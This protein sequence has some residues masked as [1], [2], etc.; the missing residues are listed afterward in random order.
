MSNYENRTVEELK[1]LL[2]ERGLP[3]FGNKADLIARLRGRTSSPGS[4]R[5][6]S[7]G[8][9]GGG[10]RYDGTLEEL[11]DLLYE[12]GLPLSG[13]RNFD[14]VSGTFEVLGANETSGDRA[15]GGSWISHWE[16]W[17]RREARECVFVGC[18]DPPTYGGHLH[19]KHKRMHFIGP[20]CAHHN[21]EL[22]DWDH[23]KQFHRTKR[24]VS[25]VSMRPRD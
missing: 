23:G 1:D 18:R 6:A 3:L 4:G 13:R 22:Y 12:R 11:R 21:S 14:V 7:G 2:W 15:P 5:A 20:V 17:T 19:V 25:L 9:G 24:E 8:G 16:T 10:G